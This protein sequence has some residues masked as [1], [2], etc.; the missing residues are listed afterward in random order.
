MITRV[1]VCVHGRSKRVGKT[2]QELR[3]SG[4]RLRGNFVEG[5][6]VG[7]SDSFHGGM[8][9]PAMSY[10]LGGIDLGHREGGVKDDSGMN[11]RLHP[12]SYI[13][14]HPDLLEKIRAVLRSID[15]QLDATLERG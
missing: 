8:V 9:H 7:I 5:E 2:I 10:A 13:R 3:R 11:K 1:R 6:E 14:A 4:T 12:F 15:L